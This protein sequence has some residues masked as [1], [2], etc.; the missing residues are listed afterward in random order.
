MSPY[1]LVYGKA[2][3]FPVEIEHRV[4]WS[5]KAINFE[6]KLA[7][8]KRLL[9]LSELEEWRLTLYENANIYEKK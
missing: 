3:H 5:I 1:K 4:Y 6:F 2:C 8:E 7:G 9:E